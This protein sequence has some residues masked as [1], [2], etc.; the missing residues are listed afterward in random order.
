MS[1]LAGSSRC[2]VSLQK[3]G[4]T[5]GVS[6]RGEFDTRAAGFAPPKYLHLP[7]VDNHAPTQED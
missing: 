5:A 4:V 6:L 3:R 7:T 1:T 2:A